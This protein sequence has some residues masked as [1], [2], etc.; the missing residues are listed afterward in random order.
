MKEKPTRLRHSAADQ[1]LGLGC[2][3]FPV[4]QRPRGVCPAVTY[5]F[6]LLK[7]I[8]AAVEELKFVSQGKAMDSVGLAN[9]V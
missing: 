2:L 5:S 9:L 7:S 3:R 4:V 1:A 6:A 8:Y